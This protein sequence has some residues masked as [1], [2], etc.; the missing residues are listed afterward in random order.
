MFRIIFVHFFAKVRFY[1]LYFPFMET[2]LPPPA[3][4]SPR[5]TP[6]KTPPKAVGIWLLIGLVMVFAQIVIGGI[7]RLTDSGLSITEWEIVRGILPPLNQTQWEEAFQLYQ[8]HAYTQ[9][10]KIHSEMTLSEFKFIYFWEYFHRLWARS[11][12]LVFLF[13]FLYFWRKKYLSK[14]LMKRLGIVVGLAALA[15]SFGWIMVASGL[16]TPVYAWVNAY[17]LT[18]HLGIATLLLGYLFWTAL[19]VLQPQTADDHNKRLKRFAWRITTVL[20]LQ[21]LLGGLMSGMKAGLFFS[22]F[23]HMQVA[24]DGSYLWIAETLKDPGQ[25][26]WSNLSNYT[27]SAF[28]PALVQL[29]HRSTAYLLCLLIPILVLTIRRMRPSKPLRY[30]SLLLLL[31]LGIQVSLGIYTLIN[32]IGSIPVTLGV[33]HQAFGFV[34]LLNLLFVNYQFSRRTN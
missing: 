7:T 27:N 24:P 23:P 26:S 16:N 34:L 25:W 33:L 15:A 6:K 5:P 29:L 18:L 2:T 22:S 10:Q 9:Y 30:G 3:P 13:P 31:S 32:C 8:T 1:K 12:G 28:A 14:T 19:S 17:K 20:V 4:I 21:I 11:M